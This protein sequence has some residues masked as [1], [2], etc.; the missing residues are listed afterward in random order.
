[1]EYGVFP[2]LSSDS[3]CLWVG[4][5]VELASRWEADRVGGVVKIGR[6]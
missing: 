3:G 1:M 4:F 2:D 6:G 5:P